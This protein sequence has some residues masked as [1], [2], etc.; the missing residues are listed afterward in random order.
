MSDPNARIPSIVPLNFWVEY[1]PQ[2][3]GT[4]REVEKVEWS[5]KGTQNTSTVEKISRLSKI[6]L[7]GDH[8]PEWEALK[9]YYERWKAGQAAPVDGTPLAAWPGAT[10]H[11]VKAL[12][13]YHIRSVQDLAELTDGT[14]AKIPLPGIRTFRD[15]ARAYVAAASTTAPIAGELAALRTKTEND[16]RRIEE[17][18][19]LVK[20]LAA[21]KGIEIAD[22]KP[23]RGRPKKAA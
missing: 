12:E 13:P 23:R 11:L 9:P 4:M 10:P 17:L 16:A 2:P 19:T 14:M 22:D 15:N 21:E 20:S 8:I 1:E 7:N 18:E 6:G 5:R 3:D